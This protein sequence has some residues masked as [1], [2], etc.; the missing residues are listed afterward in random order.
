MPGMCLGM[1][2]GCVRDVHGNAL[3]N[4]KYVH[5]FGTFGMESLGY[6]MLLSYLLKTI[7]CI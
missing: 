2:P 5:E 6:A 1:C 3:H 7:L 4:I